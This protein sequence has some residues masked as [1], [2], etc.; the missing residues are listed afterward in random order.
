MQNS[1][2]PQL[3]MRF[4]FLFN[5]KTTCGTLYS[6]INRTRDFDFRQRLLVCAVEFWFR[7]AEISISNIRLQLFEYRSVIRYFLN[8]LIHNQ[9]SIHKSS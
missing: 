1:V 7:D 6:I 2:R 8:D 9:T 3:F 4:F 5:H